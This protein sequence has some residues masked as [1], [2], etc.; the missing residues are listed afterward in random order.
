MF[1]ALVSFFWPWDEIPHRSFPATYHTVVSLV[2]C[3]LRWSRKSCE[4][5]AA[6]R[7]EA[8]RWRVGCLT[9]RRPHPPTPVLSAAASGGRRSVSLLKTPTEAC[10]CEAEESAFRMSFPGLGRGQGWSAATFPLSSRAAAPSLY[11]RSPDN[12]RG[13]TKGY[14]KGPAP[15]HVRRRALAARSRR[16]KKIVFW[17]FFPFSRSRCTYKHVKDIG[18][19]KFLNRLLAFEPTRALQCANCL[20]TSTPRCLLTRLLWG[21]P[22]APP[23]PSSD[24]DG[25]SH[26]STNRVNGLG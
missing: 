26:S 16:P 9:C 19:Q 5:H 18:K 20:L 12:I 11:L 17:F 15:S 22:S 14:G 8:V 10:G 25:V 24:G 23:P 3:R 13:A 4:R 1:A 6:G 21:S 7:L 2:W